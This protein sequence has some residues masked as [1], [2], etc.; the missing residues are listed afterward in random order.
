MGLFCG[1]ALS[2]FHHESRAGG[3]FAKEIGERNRVPPHEPESDPQIK[4][5]TSEYN[6]DL[7]AIT[8]H[9]NAT[10]MYQN[11][12]RS[13]LS[14]GVESQRILLNACKAQ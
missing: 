10:M 7:G 14:A 8:L 1:R 9:Q 5:E 4:P 13:V 3:K 12:E 11:E 2:F 6:S